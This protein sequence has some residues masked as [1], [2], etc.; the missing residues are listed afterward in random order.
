[1]FCSLLFASWLCFPPIP[2]LP[3]K[4]ETVIEKIERITDEQG[5]NTETALRIAECESQFG[6]Y[7]K[8]WEGSGATGL[9]HFMPRT[10]NAYCQGDINNDEDQIRCFIELYP[11]HPDWWQCK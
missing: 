11:K 4:C 5:F 1:M 6:K 3:P 8:N 7:R 2:V 9:Y 10:F